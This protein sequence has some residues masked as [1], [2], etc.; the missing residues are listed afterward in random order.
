MQGTRLKWKGKLGK[1]DLTLKQHV[2]DGK[3]ALVPNPGKCVFSLQAG[4]LHHQCYPKQHVPDGKWALVPNPGKCLFSL[5]V[6]F[7][8]HQCYPKQHVPDEKWALVPYPSEGS[9]SLQAGVFGN[10]PTQKQQHVP[11]GKWARVPNPGETCSACKL[12]CCF[13]HG[14]KVEILCCLP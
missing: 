3:W 5:Q 13:L 11:D 2:P 9:F 7:L 6:G 12:A 1:S 14:C 8:H 10:W 4:F